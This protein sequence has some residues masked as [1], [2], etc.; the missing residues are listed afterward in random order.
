MATSRCH[1]PHLRMFERPSRQIRV[2]IEEAQE[3]PTIVPAPLG[4]PTG[5]HRTQLK[6]SSDFSLF[7]FS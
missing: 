7:R 2:P 1:H 3:S 6:I 4:G 5:L